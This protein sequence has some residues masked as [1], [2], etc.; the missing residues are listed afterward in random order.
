MGLKTNLR[1]YGMRGLIIYMKNFWGFPLIPVDLSGDGIEKPVFLRDKT[2]DAVMFRQI[3]EDREYDFSCR[4]S[5]ECIVDLGANIGLASI[6]FANRFPKARMIAVEPE[7]SN[8]SLLKKNLRHY[9]NVRSIHAAAWSENTILRVVD[10]E[11]AQRGCKCGFQ[12]VD[13][14][15][16]G[17]TAIH[18]VRGMTVDTLM[19][20]NGLEYIDIL[21][22]DIE[23]AEKEIF[24]D[25][26]RW[27][28]SVGLLIIE[29]HERFKPGCEDA[30]KNA[31]ANFPLRW[32]N[33][34]NIFVA[35][36]ELPVGAS[37]QQKP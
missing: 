14:D 7:K 5:P 32:V 8:F 18:N 16:E 23:G 20:E 9:A 13:T 33:G 19:K 24:E 29:L 34:E 21:K 31:T 30:F 12:T 28:D 22:I 35:R 36:E 27:I 3:F 17:R 11:G 25:A 26:S 6:Y 2:D 4:F 37:P 15:P 10:P 1:K